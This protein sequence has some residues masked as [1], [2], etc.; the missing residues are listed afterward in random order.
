MYWHHIKTAFQFDT[1][2]LNSVHLLLLLVAVDDA[3]NRRSPR[4]NASKQFAEG[5]DFVFALSFGRL[6]VC[7]CICLAS[8]F[9]HNNI[10]NLI[11]NSL[12]EACITSSLTKFYRHDIQFI[13]RRLPSVRWFSQAAAQFTSHCIASHRIVN[14]KMAKFN[15]MHIFYVARCSL[16]YFHLNSQP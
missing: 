2:N 5:F 9:V 7:V 1:E 12:I 6:C 4:L 10:L 14:F 3:L 16:P 13:F 11:I 15:L 8:I